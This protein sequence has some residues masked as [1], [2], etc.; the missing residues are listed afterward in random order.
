MIDNVVFGKT[1]TVCLERG[2]LLQETF[3]MKGGVGVKAFPS[4]HTNY[5]IPKALLGN[6]LKYNFWLN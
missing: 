2:L 1:I 4:P 3:T 5:N 6:R